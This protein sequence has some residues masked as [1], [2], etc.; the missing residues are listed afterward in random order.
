L[1]P[2]LEPFF[3]PERDREREGER[4]RESWGGR[5]GERV[6]ERGGEIPF[7]GQKL[8]ILDVK[9]GAN[10]Q[11]S[12]DLETPGERAQRASKGSR[13]ILGYQCLPAVTRC[14]LEHAS[15]CQETFQYNLSAYLHSQLW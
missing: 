2:F 6:G 10:F 7:R 15:A 13:W 4:G 14:P 12:T 3:E 11:H 8:S 5:E 9:K 1:E